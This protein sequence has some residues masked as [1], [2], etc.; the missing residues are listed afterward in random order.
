MLEPTA[1]PKPH[2]F[3][4]GV[5]IG[6]LCARQDLCQC[7]H[8]RSLTTEPLTTHRTAC[9]GAPIRQSDR[10]A[11]GDCGHRLP[12]PPASLTRNGR[13]KMVRPPLRVRTHSARLWTHS[14]LPRRSRYRTQALPKAPPPSDLT[15]LHHPAPYCTFTALLRFSAGGGETLRW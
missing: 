6:V 12:A 11:K 3:V 7:L 14:P 5:E 8:L 2:P 1:H 15:L 10:K 13:V 9:G 4:S